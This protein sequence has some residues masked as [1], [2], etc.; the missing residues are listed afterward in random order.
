M[1]NRKKLDREMVE[2]K[3]TGRLPRKFRRTM[4]DKWY[5]TDAELREVLK[6]PPKEKADG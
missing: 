1:G 2:Y 4:A 5:S 6:L 3:I